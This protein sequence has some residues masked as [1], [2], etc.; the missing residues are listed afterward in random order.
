MK[1]FKSIPLL[2]LLSFSLFSCKKEVSKIQPISD[3]ASQELAKTNEDC[4]NGQWKGVYA[5]YN[6]PFVYE[7]DSK[8]ISGGIAKLTN[9]P[10]PYQDFFTSVDL[11]IPFCRKFAGD[12]AKLEVR[13]KNPSGEQGSVTDYDVNLYLYGSSDTAHVT[14]IAYRAQFTSF[15]VG[16]KQITNSPD[17]LYLF[18]D[19]S[20]VTLE[21]KDKNLSVYRDGALIKTIS[22]KGLKI[23]NLKKI[24]VGFKGSGSVDWVKLYSSCTNT[25]HMQEN[26]DVDGKSNIIW[27]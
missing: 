14:F 24:Q 18:Q 3:L 5:T 2:A 16:S 13:L 19:W 26:F 10:W 1:L 21:A 11:K 23:G 9:T 25:L 17:L 22:Y 4:G 6:L 20:T 7:D 12:T 8:F 15:G 27:Y